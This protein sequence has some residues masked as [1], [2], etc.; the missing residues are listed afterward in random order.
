M[1]HMLSL[2]RRNPHLQATVD[3]S[4]QVA[5]H[6]ICVT[7]SDPDAWFPPEPSPRSQGASAKVIALRAQYEQIA[8]ELC[9]PCPV[10]AQCL[11]LVLREEHHLSRSRISGIRGGKAPWQRYLMIYRR[12]RRASRNAA[13]QA[14]QSTARRSAMSSKAVV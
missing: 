9:G 6:G 4:E 12:R 11:E 3:L 2:P 10:R 1:R 14:R 13:R 7:S 5:T 8:R